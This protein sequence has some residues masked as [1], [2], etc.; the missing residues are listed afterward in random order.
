MPG[1]LASANKALAASAVLLKRDQ[2]VESLSA[3]ASAHDS[4]ASLLYQK[5]DLPGANREYREAL[6][7]EERSNQKD[8][9]EIETVIA[10]C[11]TLQHLGDIHGGLGVSNLGKTREAVAFYQRATDLARDLVRRAPASQPRR[12]ELY[13]TLANLGS[14]ELSMGNDKAAESHFAEALRMIEA[15]NQ[16]NPNNSS[17]R[18]EMA[19]TCLRVGVQFTSR[20]NPGGALPYFERAEAA[21][22]PL[23]DSDPKNTLYRR[24][25]SVVESHLVS[26]L[27]GLARPADALPHARK[28][29]EL[30]E[31]VL[32]INPQSAE[33]QSDVAISR[34]RVAD[35]SFELGNREAA[36]REAS[37]SV[38]AL[39][40]LSAGGDAY[41]STYLALSLVTLG[42]IEAPGNAPAAVEAYRAAREI[43]ARLAEADP[44]NIVV[45]SDLSKTELLLG[46]LYARG[47]AAADAQR[48][49]R[50]AIEIWD[51]VKQH[52]LVTA[53]TS[54]ALANCRA[55]RTVN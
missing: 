40:K 47:G 27:R 41:M 20:G 7:L 31:A 55:M 26:A 18:V 5:G 46:D 34:R 24:N 36:R 29:L 17:Y 2:S 35:V 37:A 48:F 16:E 4:F 44:S 30:A 51:Q 49:C 45:R 43:Q 23:V 10:I 19:G 42:N 15:L 13:G 11:Q 33:A 50:S 53:Q 21:M 38:A 8:P 52:G 3:A 14:I 25:L 28:S 1:A 12:R 54:S 9:E 22:Q 39:K 6:N 32:A